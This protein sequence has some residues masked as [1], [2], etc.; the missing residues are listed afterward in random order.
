MGLVDYRVLKARKAR[1]GDWLKMFKLCRNMTYCSTYSNKTPH[2]NYY[3]SFLDDI[4]VGG[5][6]PAPLTY[7][8]VL[9]MK[10][11]RQ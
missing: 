9:Q 3:P 4:G 6:T 11:G 10:H 2:D 7:L 1:M 8:D 5:T